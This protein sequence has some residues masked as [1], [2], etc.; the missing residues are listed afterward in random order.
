M[1]LDERFKPR[2]PGASSGFI[3]LRDVRINSAIPNR[4]LDWKYVE[5]LRAGD[6]RQLPQMDVM[7]IPESNYFELLDG[8]HRWWAIFDFIVSNRHDMPALDGYSDFQQYIRD[9][10]SRI[11]DTI[12]AR[13]WPR[14]ESWEIPLFRFWRNRDHGLNES[15]TN[16][17]EVARQLKRA[18]PLLTLEQIAQDVR[19]SVSFVSKAINETDFKEEKTSDGFKDTRRFCSVIEKA[20]NNGFFNREQIAVREK[21]LRDDPNFCEAYEGIAKQMLKEVSRATK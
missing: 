20:F 16:C 12:H 13:M 8:Q 9:C 15:D 4:P 6:V 11:D 3:K 10:L 7:Q 5:Q 14:L 1:T 19:R 21:W 2:E 17:K 18:N